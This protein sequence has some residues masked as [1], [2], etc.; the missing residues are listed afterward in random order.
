[1]QAAQAH[2][3]QNFRFDGVT[4]QVHGTTGI[5]QNTDFQRVHKNMSEIE[6]TTA[7]MMIAICN[8]CEV[9]LNVQCSNLRHVNKRHQVVTS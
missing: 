5:Q 2:M 1:M 8:A 4:R 7:V 3:L 9:P 6:T